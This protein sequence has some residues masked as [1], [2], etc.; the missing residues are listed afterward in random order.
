MAAQTITS[1]INIMGNRFDPQ[2]M[3]VPAGTTVTWHNTTSAEHGITCDEFEA[4]LRPGQD[5]EYTF[6][7][8][9]SYAVVSSSHAGVEGLRVTITVE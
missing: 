4:T 7:N 5:Y 8:A 1:T 3:T 2:E 9:G 6:A